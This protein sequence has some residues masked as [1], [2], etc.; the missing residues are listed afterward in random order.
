MYFPVSVNLDADIDTFKK[1][2]EI[3]YNN[4]FFVKYLTSC[5]KKLITFQKFHD[6]HDQLIFYR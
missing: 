3:V 2:L 1:K 6:T 5:G 4:I